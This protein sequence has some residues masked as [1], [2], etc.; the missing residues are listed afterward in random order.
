VLQLRVFADR[1]E[2][3]T[4]G[5]VAFRAFG[6]LCDDLGVDAVSLYIDANGNGRVDPGEF[7]LAGPCT[8][9]ADD[10]LVTFSGL[11]RTFPASSTETWLLAFD[12][13]PAAPCGATFGLSLPSEAQISRTGSWNPLP[14]V[15]GLPVQSATQQVGDHGTLHLAAGQA[16]APQALP[17]DCRVPVLHM[18]VSAGAGEPVRVDSFVLRLAGTLSQPG[19]YLSLSLFE[20]A[21]GNR[22]YDSDDRLLRGPVPVVPGSDMAIF[23]DLG[24][25]VPQ[26]GNLD[27]FVTADFSQDTPGGTHFSLA[28]TGDTDL[29]ATGA[30][31]GEGL[32]TWGLPLAGC[33]VAIVEGVPPSSAVSDS[34]EGGGCA[35]GIGG[36]ASKTR[37]LGFLLLW[38][39]LG[40]CLRICRRAAP[41]REIHSQTK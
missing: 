32:Q 2:A 17:G 36:P 35:A 9:P 23:W 28:L 15:A 41:R 37:I 25:T 26:S 27:W 34:G 33:E 22:V 21:N 40:L 1:Y 6:T 39:A 3:I 7:R 5:H 38:T 19:Q 30:L 31:Y 16:T 11:S 10:G 8:F 4:V 12:L 29:V 18:E 24:L 13:S 20:D 14:H